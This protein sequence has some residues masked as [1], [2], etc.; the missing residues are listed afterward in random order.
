MF[1]GYCSY[2]YVLC[3][4]RMEESSAS[5]GGR[6]KNKR[7]WSVEEDKVLVNA[8]S[9]LAAD[10]HWRCEAGFRNGY[11]NR[12]EE[13]IGKT[14]P[15]CGLK[16]TLH[17]DSRLKTLVAK[18]RAISQMLSTSGF[19]WDDEK[20]MISV[21]RAVYDEYCKVCITC[22]PLNNSLYQN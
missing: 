13:V 12:L 17:I 11:M 6:G 15:S 7:F 18:F 21:E 19:A 22:H 8:S 3:F 5:G 4:S 10:T 9:E 2:V 16:A 1:K 20:K 14:L